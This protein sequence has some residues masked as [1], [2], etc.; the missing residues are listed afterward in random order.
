VRVSVLLAATAGAGAATLFVLGMEEK[1]PPPIFTNPAVVVEAPRQPPLGSP[2][3][4]RSEAERRGIAERVRDALTIEEDEPGWDCRTMGNRICGP[5]AP[6]PPPDGGPQPKPLPGSMVT[7]EDGTQVPAS[8]Y[9]R[10]SPEYAASRPGEYE[11][12][13][14]DGTWTRVGGG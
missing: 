7:A 12:P 6:E 3:H 14:G 1:P 10:V 8:F 11:D 4:L 9:D 5:L 2:L 13:D